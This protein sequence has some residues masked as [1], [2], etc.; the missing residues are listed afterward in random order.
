MH[1]TVLVVHEKD[2]DIHEL[3]AP[4]QENNMGDCPEI[5]LEFEDETEDI[6]RQFDQLSEEQKVQYPTFDDYAVNYWGAVKQGEQYGHVSNP[7]AEWDW[8]QIGGRWANFFLLKPG[9]EGIRGEHSALDKNPTYRDGYYD[10]ACI[11]DIDFDTM[12]K[13]A[14]DRAR[15]KH[16]AVMA[17][18]NE[19]GPFRDWDSFRNLATERK[20]TMDEARDGY[21]AQPAVV[22]FKEKFDPFVDRIENYTCCTEEEFVQRQLDAVAGVYAILKDGEWRTSDA[23]FFEQANEW[24]KLVTETYEDL[25]LNNPEIW[26]TVVDCHR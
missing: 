21:H 2:E 25:L 22:A 13:L 4:F 23:G 20:L 6:K 7:N 10:S 5:Y 26:V 16:V 18:A 12:R 8:Y 9:K 3:L 17:I 14:E 15:T 1:F 24:D 11:S 19:H